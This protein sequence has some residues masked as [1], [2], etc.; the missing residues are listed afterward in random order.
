MLIVDAYTL[1]AAQSAPKWFNDKEYTPG[2][3]L[4]VNNENGFSTLKLFTQSKST[5]LVF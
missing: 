4:K 3:P 5:V 1:K 2:V